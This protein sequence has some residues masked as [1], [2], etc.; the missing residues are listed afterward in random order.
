MKQK[1]LINYLLLA[2]VAYGALWLWNTR[3]V[4]IP[5]GFLP[6]TIS[7]EIVNGT[8]VC[9]EGYKLGGRGVAGPDCILQ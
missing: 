5:K 1:Q 6:S 3:T 9:P 7:P 8:W 2:G 4:K